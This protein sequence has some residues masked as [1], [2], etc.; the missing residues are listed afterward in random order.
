MR[1]F[2]VPQ[3]SRSI[4]KRMKLAVKRR[5]FWPFQQATYVKQDSETDFHASCHRTNFMKPKEA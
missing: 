1:G 3:A 5:F 2:M 4:V